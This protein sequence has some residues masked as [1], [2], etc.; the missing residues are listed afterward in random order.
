MDVDSVVTRRPG[1]LFTRL[2]DDL[3]AIDP[4]VECCY[5]LN[6]PAARVWELIEEPTLVRDVCDRLGEEFD[7]DRTICAG[8]VIELLTELQGASLIDVDGRP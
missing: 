6:G 5:S 1:P 8:D 4:Q 3:L 2:D 7:V